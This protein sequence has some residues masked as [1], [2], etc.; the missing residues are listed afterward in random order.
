MEATWALYFVGLCFRSVQNSERA[1][2]GK[3]VPKSRRQPSVTN[4]D[5]NAD[6]NVIKH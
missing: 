3:P 1:A 4:A 5:D 2:H 6:D